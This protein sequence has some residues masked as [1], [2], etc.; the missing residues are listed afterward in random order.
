MTD[1]RK[2]VADL[3]ARERALQ[4]AEFL[5]PRVRGGQVTT[6]VQGLAY[7]FSLENRDFEGWGIF[8]P[9]DEARV[10]LV[11]EAGLAEVAS[12]LGLFPA[13]RFFLADHLEGAT[14]LAYPVNESDARQ[15]LGAVKP[16]PVHLVTDGARF[17]R[18]VARWDG[19]ALWFEELDR[20]ADPRDVERCREA[21]GEGA[22]AEELAWPGLTPELRATYSIAVQRTPRAIAQTR[23]RVRLERALQ[24][25][26]GQ[27]QLHHEHGD[28]WTVEWSTADGERHVSAI[29]KS[30]LTVVSAGICLAGGDRAFDL[31]SLV[32]VVEGRYD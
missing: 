25:G 6:R 9:I 28:Y 15:R 23:D 1:P 16:L 13:I 3:A 4:G 10:R 21:I 26:G 31:Q 20:R 22:R 5:A 24:R 2:I 14:W 8:Q 30:D 27:L 18:I 11:S 19:R 17:E 12:Y 29:S 7:T 32:G